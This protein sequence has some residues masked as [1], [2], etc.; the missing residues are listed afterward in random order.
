M[1]MNVSH[2]HQCLFIHVPRTAGCSIAESGFLSYRGHFPPANELSNIEPDIWKH[3][4]T[5][6]FVRNPWDRFVS[7]YFYF[8]QMRPGHRWHKGKNVR[9]ARTVKQFATFQSF[10]KSFRQTDLSDD[11]HFREQ[12]AWIADPT[13][14]ILVDF[15]GHVESLQSDVDWIRARLGLPACKLPHLN[16]SAHR[17]YTHYY[18]PDTQQ[19]VTDIYARDA[20][21]LGYCFASRYHSEF[22]QDKWIVEDVFMR[23]RGGFFVDVGA[24][25][26]I[27][28]SN[29]YALEKYYGW[30]GICVEPGKAFVELQRNRRCITDNSCLGRSSGQTVR[31][32]NVAR[33]VHLSGIEEYLPRDHGGRSLTGHTVELTTSTLHDVLRA[34]DAPVHIDYLSIDTG[35]SEYAV[36][37]SFPFHLYTF[38]AITVAHAPQE[39]H[40]ASL[41]ELLDHNGY[42]RVRSDDRFGADDR[43][44][45]QLQRETRGRATAPFHGKEPG[46]TG[47]GQ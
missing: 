14:R 27:R 23:K 47:W 39:A 35:G 43:Y 31:F 11:L 24:S 36:L 18:D 40:R 6:C 21:A 42:R 15:V 4:F 12:L 16:S 34:H 38:G 8:R 25:D 10:C 1:H 37:Q 30:Q 44:I 41:R 2:E 19:I 20:Q 17:H 13:G 22:G 7:T 5:F 28:R 46:S 9:V 33:D 26:G 45:R 29:T 3:Y 32:R